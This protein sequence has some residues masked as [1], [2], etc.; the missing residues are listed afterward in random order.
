MFPQDKKFQDILKS[1]IIISF[2]D[3]L[4]LLDEA[5]SDYFNQE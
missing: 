1:N 5:F 4:L 2:I 3:N